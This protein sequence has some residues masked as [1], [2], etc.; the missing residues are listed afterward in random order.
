MSHV[1]QYGAS[2]MESS[3]KT[4]SRPVI[5]RLPVEQIDEFAC[6]QLDRV[7]YP[8]YILSTILFG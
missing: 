5:N 6:R 3:V 4:I 7:S 8:M 2:I 1:S